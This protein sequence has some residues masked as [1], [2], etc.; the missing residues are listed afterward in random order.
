MR[1]LGGWGNS[2]GTGSPTGQRTKVLKFPSAVY[3]RTPT[4]ALPPHAYS[5]RITFHHSFQIPKPEPNT[6]PKKVRKPKPKQR[7]ATTPRVPTKTIQERLENRREYDKAK[8][9]APVL[10]ASQRK[11]YRQRQVKRTELCLCRDC[12]SPAIENQVRCEA[13]RNKHNADGRRRNAERKAQRL[14]R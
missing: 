13:C 12:A 6:T 10:K 11:L 1:S 4:L 14:E 5:K 2:C 8:S 3:L 9:Q 7:K